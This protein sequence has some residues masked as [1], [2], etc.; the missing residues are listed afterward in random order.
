[1]SIDVQEAIKAIR[2]ML[3]IIDPEEDYLTIVAAEE[4]IV[5]SEAKRKKE[6][7][8]AHAK[9]KALT[10]ICE[11]ARI[12]STRPASIPSQEDHVAMLNELENS[13]LSLAKAISDAEGLSGSKEAELAAL[14]EEARRLEGYDPAVEHTKELDGSALRLQLYKGLGFEPINEPNRN[15]SKMLVRAT[16]GDIHT[17]DLS[18]SKSKFENTQLLWKLANS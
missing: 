7:E 15:I 14:K 9:L 2:D 10:R 5:A 11:A 6:L 12:S 1:M 13:K 16:S 3:P 8:E 18:N 17:V 4:K